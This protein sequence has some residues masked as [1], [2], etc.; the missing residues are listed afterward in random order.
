MHR[1]LRASE[2]SAWEK[3]RSALAG[4]VRGLQVQTIIPRRVHVRKT[5]KEEVPFKYLCWFCHRMGLERDLYLIDD[6]EG[7]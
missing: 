7:D 1:D 5:G 3:G 2:G 4:L 6:A